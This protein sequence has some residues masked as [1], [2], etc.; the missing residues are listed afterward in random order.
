MLSVGEEYAMMFQDSGCV[1]S[2]RLSS[3]AFGTAL[4]EILAGMRSI[5]QV[6][7]YKTLSPKRV[8]DPCKTPNYNK[9][10]LPR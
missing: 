8:L 6:C 1:F 9:A 3:F 10:P 5:S 2:G 7:P 4:L